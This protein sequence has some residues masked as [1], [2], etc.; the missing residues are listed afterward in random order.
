MLPAYTPC[1]SGRV[2]DRMIAPQALIG[3]CAG[4]SSVSSSTP[5]NVHID[6]AQ[7]F[8]LNRRPSLRPS[9]NLVRGARPSRN[10]ALSSRTSYDASSHL[11]PNAATSR[12]FVVPYSQNWSQLACSNSTATCREV[13]NGVEKAMKTSPGGIKTRESNSPTFPIRLLGSQPNS[14]SRQACSFCRFGFW[15]CVGGI[16]AH[17]QPYESNVLPLSK[18]WRFDTS[19]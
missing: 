7:L 10:S 8:R 13:R 17:S 1:L 11:E 19:G 14:F 18:C 2:I 9:R 12:T 4:F 3:S 6:K 16:Q 5:I 15:A